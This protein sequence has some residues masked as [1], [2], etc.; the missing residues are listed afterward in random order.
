M[1]MGLDMSMHQNQE[2]TVDTQLE[3][4]T[5]PPP[6]SIMGIHH[7]GVGPQVE[8]PPCFIVDC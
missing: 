7:G 2:Y 8:T 1:T 5:A 6:E 4:M 3:T